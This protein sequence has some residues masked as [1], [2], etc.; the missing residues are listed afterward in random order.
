MKTLD[1]IFGTG[2]CELGF[3]TVNDHT[4][5]G[6]GLLTGLMTGDRWSFDRSMTGDRGSFDRGYD[7][8]PVVF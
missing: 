7:R 8:R 5:F 4:N 6:G 2:F 1:L 3:E